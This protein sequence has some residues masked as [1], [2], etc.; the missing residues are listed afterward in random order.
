M[1]DLSLDCSACGKKFRISFAVKPK[2]VACPQCKAR[3]N[4]L[5]EGAPN[6]VTPPANFAPPGM[7]VATA[8]TTG[9][10]NNAAPPATKTR[11]LPDPK[12]PQTKPRRVHTLLKPEDVEFKGWT[13]DREAESARGGMQHADVMG[14]VW[15]GGVFLMVG[16]ILFRVLKNKL[17]GEGFIGLGGVGL[18]SAG[19]LLMQLRGKKDGSACLRCR[20]ALGLV[21]TIPTANECKAKNYTRGASGHAYRIDNG[22][23]KKIWEI[24][25]KWHVCKACKRYFIAEK[26]SL[27]FVGATRADLEKREVLYGEVAAAAMRPPQPVAAAV[28]APDTANAP[29][30]A[31]PV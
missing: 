24:H 14:I 28:S 10:T 16:I 8:G 25:K 6:G 21:H 31:N 1:T 30:E 12:A 7:D 3:V 29:V 9:S 23:A 18:L 17:V 5:D 20:G 22:Q 2:Q 11:A 13:Y 27:D 15:L 26:E 4:T 19:Y